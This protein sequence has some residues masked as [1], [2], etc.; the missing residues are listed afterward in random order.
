[1]SYHNGTV[2]PHD[3]S[4]AVAGLR[5]YRHTAAASQVIEGI[6]EAGFR[7]PNYRL[8]E[9]FCG[10]RRD[11]RFNNGPAEYLVSCNP[12]AWGAGAAFHLLQSALG[13]VPDA[14]AGRVY[15]NPIPFGQARTVEVRGMRVGSGR[16]SFTVAYNGGRPQVEVL[17]KP[18]DL[19]VVLD[20][21]PLIT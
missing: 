17:E 8:P 14:T 2:W 10:F 4:I 1:M 9:L 15:L 18:D 7:M 3:N 16:L 11:E 19:T 12:Q 6:M 21:P 13:V 20:E 5:R